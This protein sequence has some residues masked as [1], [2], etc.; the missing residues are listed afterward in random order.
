MIKVWVLYWLIASPAG[1][2]AHAMG[3]SRDRLTCLNAAAQVNYFVATLDHRSSVLGA[4]CG[5][6]KA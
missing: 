6:S 2:E 1:V 5:E 3:A 4:I